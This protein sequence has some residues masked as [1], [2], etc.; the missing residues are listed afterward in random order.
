MRY[1]RERERERR[2]VVMEG[3]TV[4]AQKECS[5]ILKIKKETKL[6]EA[7]LAGPGQ[8]RNRTRLLRLSK[9]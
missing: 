6:V 3:R 1:K 2:V 9:Q 7:W 5:F 4:R 8:P